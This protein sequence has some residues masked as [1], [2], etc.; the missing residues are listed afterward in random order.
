MTLM[1]L[2]KHVE[3]IVYDTVIQMTRKINNDEATAPLS[4]IYSRKKAMIA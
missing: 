1:H 2:E 3:V 4:A